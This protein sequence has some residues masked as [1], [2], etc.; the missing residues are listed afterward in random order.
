MPQENSGVRERSDSRTKE[1]RRYSVIFHNDDFTPMEFVTF[2]LANIFYLNLNE[3]ERLMLK[4][5]HEGKAVVGNYSYDVALSKVS[6]TTSLARHYGY[7]LRL[8]IEPI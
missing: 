6:K 8:T 5:H 3:A 2:V 1:P 4:V 7:P